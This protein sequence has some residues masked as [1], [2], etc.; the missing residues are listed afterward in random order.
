MRCRRRAS[1]AC[2]SSGECPPC[3]SL[4]L[5]AHSHFK[6]EPVSLFCTRSARSCPIEQMSIVGTNMTVGAA[7]RSGSPTLAG[8]SPPLVYR[9]I[10]RLTRSL[11]LL[12]G[13]ARAA[14]RVPVRWVGK[15]GK[16]ARARGAKIRAPIIHQGLVSGNAQMS[17]AGPFR[18]SSLRRTRSSFFHSVHVVS[19]WSLRR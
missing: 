10:T 12:A 11:R 1:T 3:E 17:V 7:S 5:R 15:P 13:M 16:G 19:F 18:S 8:A 9:V 2:V 6:A 4:I 14:W